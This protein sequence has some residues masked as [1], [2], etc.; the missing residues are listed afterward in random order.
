MTAFLLNDWLFWLVT[1]PV[2]LF[3]GLFVANGPLWFDTWQMHKRHYGVAGPAAF[4]RFV[5]IVFG[6]P[7]DAALKA[8]GD[9]QP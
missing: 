8:T 9:P 1:V 5:A 2:A 7:V 3:I 4:L 6:L